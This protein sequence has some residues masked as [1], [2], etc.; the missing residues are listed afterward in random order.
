MSSDTCDDSEVEKTGEASHRFIDV[1][2][3][4]LP[5]EVPVALLDFPWYLNP[6]D[7]AIWLGEIEALASLGHRIVFDASIDTFDRQRLDRLLPPHGVV[8]LTGGGN[9]GDLWPRHQTHREM[10]LD[11]LRD[12]RIVQLP[13]T[14]HFED[15]LQGRRSLARMAEHPD[16]AV[17]VRDRGSLDLLRS[18]GLDAHLSM[19][20]SSELRFGGAVPTES[21]RPAEALCL[22][23]RDREVRM[24]LPIELATRAQ[25]WSDLGIAV[26]S[27]LLDRSLERVDRLQ[28][29][30]G[31]MAPASTRL[32]TIRFRRFAEM[33]VTRAMTAIRGHSVVVTDRLHGML[34]ALAAGRPTI[35]IETGYGKI[36]SYADTFLRDE[37]LLRLL[38]DPRDVDDALVRIETPR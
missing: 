30:A 33:Q 38:S 32:R 20:P 12:R 7:A 4:L 37:P 24:H 5:P 31:R 6:G 26:P 23:R 2:A 15:E 34:L 10:L 27:S 21:Q 35:A 11:T 29:R 36:A 1:V 8:L 9:L 3:R 19:D 18:A 13:Q 22:F 28:Q 14:V 25:D 16:L 17:M